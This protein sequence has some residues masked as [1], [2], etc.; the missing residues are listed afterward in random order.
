MNSENQPVD[1]PDKR[2]QDLARKL[3]IITALFASVL[4]ILMIA[5][6]IQTKTI[7]PLKS[8]AL[9]QLML[10]LQKEPENQALKEQI[11]A[12]DLLAR[13]A[14]F[15]NQWQ[16]RTGGFLLFA[17][18]IILL[19]A[20]KYLK[21]QKD[22]FPDL[23]TSAP[24][25]LS[26]DERILARKSIVT[27][28]L[29]LIGLALVTG[30]LSESEIT[31]QNSDNSGAAASPSIEEIRQNWNGFRGAQ[32]QGIAYQAD[33]PL[34]WDGPS[35]KNIVWKLAVPR[36]GFNSPIVWGSHIFFSGADKEIQEVYCIDSRTGT[37]LWTVPLTDIPGTPSKKPKVTDDTGYAAPTMT[38]DG[39]HVYVIFATGDIACLD[40]SGNRIWV[41]NLGVPD[42][43]YGHSSSL[44]LYEN[45][46]LI[47]YDN[48]KNKQL[49]AL[50]KITGDQVY[51]TAR[52]EQ[53]SWSSPILIDHDK[54][55]QVV[56]NSNPHVI[57]YDPANGQ[58][59]W[60]VDC[61]YGEVAPS[62]AYADPYV[63]AVNEFAVLA[64]IKLDDP[65]VVAWEFDE[66]L[67][68]V[69]SPVA[70]SDI[71]IVPTSSGVVSCFD[72]RS[73]ERLW[74]QEFED[75]FYSSPIIAGDRIY[76][77]D[78]RGIA[79]ILRADRQYELLSTS[80]LGEKATTTPAFMPG[81]I[82][83]RGEKHL[84]CIGN[85]DG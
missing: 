15:T 37:I 76:L 45:L 79:Y 54:R 50:Q 33:L 3:V 29:I 43:H 82:Y 59:L 73:G 4:S 39:Q 13:R 14:Y 18:L 80:T 32:G 34:E 51:V 60:R 47:Q 85:P 9:S 74:M 12:L 17:S 35:G 56:L 81:R 23:S 44:L 40:F 5:N 21:A 70:S 63:F 10:Q 24:P 65:P 20:L 52:E 64:A 2:W 28:G 67:S 8:P 58:E 71:L 1:P 11:R 61:L 19:L 36:P 22:K 53:I 84:F 30:I 25:D 38:T 78:R 26:W 75:G 41:K 46:L 42:N 62:P 6:Y 57:G 55:T 68:E 69:S 7:E 27:V 16:V 66:D 48:N 49:I 77:M 83:I 72:T 31:I